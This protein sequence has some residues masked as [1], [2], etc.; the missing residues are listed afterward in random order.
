M[1]K[2]KLLLEYSAFFRGITFSSLRIAVLFSFNQR[3]I[4]TV[5]ILI[6]RVITFFAGKYFFFTGLILLLII[7][8][9]RRRYN[10]FFVLLRGG[11]CTFRTAGQSLFGT[12]QADLNKLDAKC[13]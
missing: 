10:Y 12:F 1:L 8:F 6:R 3:I 13:P 2:C 5:L 9:S 7:F 11:S 4:I